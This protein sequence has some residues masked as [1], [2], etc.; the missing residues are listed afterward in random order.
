VPTV[1]LRPRSTTEILDAAV[2]LL[3]RH[4]PPLFTLGVIALF[5]MMI[6]GVVS[7]LVT[8][9]TTTVAGAFPP[10]LVPVFLIGFP[11][12]GV[13]FILG[14]AAII[15]AA[16]DAYLGNPVSVAGA[17]RRALSRWPSVLGAVLLK[18]IIIFSA[19]MGASLLAGI[20]AGVLAAIAGPAGA[21]VAG[22]IAVVLVAAMLGLGLYLYA[23]LFAVP[24]TVVLEDRSAGSAIGRARELARGEMV[25]I[26]KVFA[27]VF[28]LI[29]FTSVALIAASF[30]LAQF[31]AF[32]Q[33]VAMVPY[34][35]AYPALDTVTAVLYYDIRA[36]K[37]GY[38]LELMA[39]ELAAEPS[40]RP[41][42]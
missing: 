7:A 14:D 18:A 37:E 42:F 41:A 22:L 23:M 39:Q 29:L 10:E 40:P 17:L 12:A 20:T 27:L 30:F 31:S 8:D 5:P 9:P 26:V 4:F 32:A 35:L 24:A 1:A 21:I 11:I 33:V 15:A 25:K 19:F 34:A 2:Q 6:V 3:R 36:R 28:V 13:W 38:D 16:S